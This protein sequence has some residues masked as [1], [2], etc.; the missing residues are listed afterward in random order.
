MEAGALGAQ[1]LQGRAHLL[2]ASLSTSASPKGPLPAPRQMEGT[3]HLISTS[4]SANNGGEEPHLILVFFWVGG[5]MNSS[6][7][8]FGQSEEN[9]VILEEQEA[10]EYFQHKNSKK[11]GKSKAFL[12][13]TMNSKH[14]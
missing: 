3:G 2:S 5:N 10:E 1:G 8:L 13:F 7:C 14:Y 9:A 6:S 12:E 4:R 11:E